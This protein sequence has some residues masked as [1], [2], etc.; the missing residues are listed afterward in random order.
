MKTT[1]TRSHSN[2][3]TFILLLIIFAFADT[4]VAQEP[5]IID[6]TCDDLL[7]IPSEWIEAAKD[8]LWIGYGHT[9]HGSQLTSG[10]NA[11]ESY[12]NDGTYNW[13]H[14]GGEGLLHMFEGDGYGDGYLDHDC[15]YP[16]WDDE[17]REYLDLFPD[18]NVIM[19]SWCGQ[20]N[21]VDLP[22]HYL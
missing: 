3:F 12:Y 14:E 20:V 18:C 4:G 2:V 1:S 7:S 11:V 21:S 16:G 9:S 22:S 5:V 8:N 13:S 6:H 19:W 15:G 10:M 17:T